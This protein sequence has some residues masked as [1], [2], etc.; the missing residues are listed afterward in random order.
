[1]FLFCGFALVPLEED[2][3]RFGNP[4]KTYGQAAVLNAYNLYWQCVLHFLCQS[5]NPPRL[6]GEV[7]DQE[8]IMTV[9]RT[10]RNQRIV[11]VQMMLR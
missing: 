10:E 7:M 1:M 4:I 9:A 8:D 11:L 3:R 6:T 5:T 2:T